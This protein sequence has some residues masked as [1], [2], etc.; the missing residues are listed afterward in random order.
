MDNNT[1]QVT[2]MELTQKLMSAAKENGAEFMIG[3]VS[4]IEMED[5]ENTGKL[6]KIKS[7]VLESGETI[8]CSI[9]IVAM[10]PWS[11]LAEEWF[12][13]PIPM[14]G[15]KSTSLV[16]KDMEDIKNEPYALFCSEDT[17]GCHLEVYPRPNG[18]VYICGCGGSDYVNA[19]RLKKGGDCSKPE[20]IKEDEKRVE[21][22]GKSFG[23]ISNLGKDLKP[24][25]VQSCMRP[26]PPDGLPIMGKVP[27]VEGAYICAGHNCW[28][29]LWAP[30]SGLAM[31]ELVKDGF[32]ETIDLTPFSPSR[33]MNLKEG[34]R[35][36]KVGQISVGEQW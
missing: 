25:L 18:E 35:G 26:C 22:A 27:N 19:G 17:N 16:Y 1:A 7:V 30:I 32:S 21:A 15:I 8:A 24:S 3:T 12:N 2:P 5:S 9:V 11:V 20:L 36:K 31:S 33:F 6:K 34:K 4:D 10:G 28:G 14:E 29:I 13:I 23:T